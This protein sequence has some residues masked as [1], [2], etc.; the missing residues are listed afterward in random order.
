MK[1][2]TKTLFVVCAIL[3]ITACKKEGEPDVPTA[4]K[5]AFEKLSGN[6]SLGTTGSIK[7]DGNDISGNYDGFMLSFTN[8]GY[9]TTNAGEL[10]NATGTWEWSNPQAGE[11]TLDGDR[12]V[13]INNLTTSQFMFSFTFS[14]SGGVRAGTEGSYLITVVK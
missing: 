14:G 3:I 12:S 11:I 10:L 6:W 13:T 4:Q 9:T 5:E 7:L 2:L 1:Y 8:G